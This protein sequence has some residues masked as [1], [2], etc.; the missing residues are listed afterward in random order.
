MFKALEL[1]SR[2]RE[3]AYF[4]PGV[5]DEHMYPAGEIYALTEKSSTT[6]ALLLRY[7]FFLPARFRP[8]QIVTSTH[9]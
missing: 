3:I 9:E 1:V 8:Q 5:Q 7:P 6:N 4:R 2:A